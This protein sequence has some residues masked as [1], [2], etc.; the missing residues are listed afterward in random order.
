MKSLRIGV[1]CLV[2][3]LSTSAGS[4]ASTWTIDK[5]THCRVEVPPS[6]ESFTVQWTGACIDGL[7]DGSGVLKGFSNGKV[8]EFYYGRVKQGLLDLG[9]VETSEGYVAGRFKEGKA[10]DE[11]DRQ[12]YI[13]AFREAVAAAKQASEFYRRKGNSASAKYYANKA[14]TL[15]QQMD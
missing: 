13:L 3:M 8:R 5:A 6:W 4:A 2:A 12:T 7:A 15:D 1:F 14:T 10:A 11:G 9:V